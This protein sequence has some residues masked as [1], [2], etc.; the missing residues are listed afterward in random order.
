MNKL[1]N[2]TIDEYGQ[3]YFGVTDLYDLI[4]K[5]IDVS[6][7]LIESSPEYEKLVASSKLLDNEEIVPPLYT[8]TTLPLE[9][10]M[11]KYRET[12]NIPHRYKTLDLKTWLLSLCKTREQQA[13]VVDELA[14]YE[15]YDLYPMLRSLIFLIETLKKNKVLWGI[16]RGSSVSSYVLYL[17]GVHRVDSLKYDLDFSEFLN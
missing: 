8:K 12:W 11:A 17:I 2:R 16:G 14:V 6:E 5:D 15:K 1:D 3:V 13:R 10:V 7:L 9:E 4:L